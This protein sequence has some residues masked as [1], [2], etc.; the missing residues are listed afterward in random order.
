M[1]K[2]CVICEHRKTFSRGVKCSRNADLPVN[3]SDFFNDVVNKLITIASNNNCLITILSL[4]VIFI[5]G[6]KSKLE[7]VSSC[8]T[9]TNKIIS[10][11]QFKNS[12][13]PN[14]LQTDM[15]HQ[16]E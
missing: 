6:L 15:C 2:I 5:D 12:C 16:D 9:A 3:N 14:S 8:Q 11:N 4:F 1:K 10:I 7:V 13:Q